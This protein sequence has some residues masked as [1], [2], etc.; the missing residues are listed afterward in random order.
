MTAARTGNADAVQA[1]VAHG[2]DVNAREGWRGQ[3]ALMWAASREQRR[4]HPRAG[5]RRRGHPREVDV[6]HVHA[7]AVRG[8]RRSRRRG[9]RAARG[10][11]RRQRAAA[12]RHERAGA[13][14]LQRALRAGGVPARSR[15]RPQRRRAGMD[16]AASGRVV[17]AAEPRL[18][19]AR[20]RADRSL[21]SLELV[22]R[23]RRARRRYQR[24]PDQRAARRQPQHAESDRR[25][26]V[27]DGGE[28]GRR[29]ADAAAARG[30]RRSRVWRP[31]TAPRR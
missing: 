6:R 20:R 29:P 7:A 16:R 22:R 31:T 13:G 3:T 19:P 9:A 10:R 18:Q 21:D 24:A 25:D 4:R 15:R 14:G 26:A 11:R 12:R 1:L 30:R 17:A 5:G 8:A 23:L 28:I 2:A 27:R